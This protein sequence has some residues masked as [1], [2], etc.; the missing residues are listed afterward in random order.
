MALVSTYRNRSNIPRQQSKMFSFVLRLDIE[1][2]GEGS[3]IDSKT[4]QNYV[5]ILSN[6]HQSS[7]HDKD[8]GHKDPTF[9]IRWY[10]II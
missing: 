5:Q 4:K 2:A 9:V 7:N 1:I 10:N 6:P 3:W 8:T